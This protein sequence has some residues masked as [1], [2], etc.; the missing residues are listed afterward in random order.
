[1]F[2]EEGRVDSEAF[3]RV[4]GQ[5]WLWVVGAFEVV[6]TMAGAKACFS[7]RVKDEL[8]P[9]KKTLAFLRM[10]FA[11]QEYPGGGKKIG[12]EASVSDVHKEE[13]DISYRVEDEVFSVRETLRQ[14]EAVMGGIRRQSVRFWMLKTHPCEVMLLLGINVQV[15]IVLEIRQRNQVEKIHAA[16][17]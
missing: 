1:M 2:D 12:T 11:K 4:Y 7:Q 14:F 15:N 10:P 17:A 6:R 5:F 9:L 3:D 16:E 8:G 13:R